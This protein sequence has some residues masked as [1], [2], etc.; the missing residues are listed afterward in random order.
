MLVFCW[1][2]DLITIIKISVWH[3][4]G[5]QQWHTDIIIFSER[6]SCVI[7]DITVYL[8]E[9]VYFLKYFLFL[10]YI[11]KDRYILLL[12]RFNRFLLVTFCVLTTFSALKVLIFSLAS[13]YPHALAFFMQNNHL[14]KAS[15]LFW[16]TFQIFFFMSCDCLLSYF[17]QTDKSLCLL[18]LLSGLTVCPALFWFLQSD[19]PQANRKINILT[20]FPWSS[21]LVV[22]I[23]VCAPNAFCCWSSLCEISLFA[24]WR[25]WNMQYVQLQASIAS[26]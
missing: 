15:D 16:V 17:Q 24:V 19:R 23:K 7:H 18:C 22:E 6:H 20:W 8:Q 14:Y 25:Y 3:F 10:R 4:L 13:D 2:N 9:P 5:P 21:C 11:H 1:K 26:F 12:N